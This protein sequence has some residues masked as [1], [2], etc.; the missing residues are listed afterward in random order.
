MSPLPRSVIIE[1]TKHQQFVNFAVTLLVFETPKAIEN[2][3][4][5]TEEAAVFSQSNALNPG[6]LIAA[7]LSGDE[8]VSI[9]ERIVRVI[10]SL[11]CSVLPGTRSPHTHHWSTRERGNYPE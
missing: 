3:L 6:E 1:R 4:C 8:E 2:L 11:K 10:A 5:N 7:C 9:V